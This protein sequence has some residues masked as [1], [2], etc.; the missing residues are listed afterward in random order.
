MQILRT[1][2]RWWTIVLILFALAGLVLVLGPTDNAAA[3]A[4][5]DSLEEPEVI[6][7]SSGDI[8]V[9]VGPSTLVG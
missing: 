3:S 2:N 4:I 1:A 7:L 5:A 6:I 9:V 8:A